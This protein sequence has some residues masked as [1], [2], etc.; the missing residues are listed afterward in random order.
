VGVIQRCWLIGNLIEGLFFHLMV[1]CSVMIQLAELNH[2]SSTF[3]DSVAEE[4]SLEIRGVTKL[5]GEHK[6][7]MQ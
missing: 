1:N 2:S 5:V 4:F 6:R 3:G 7:D